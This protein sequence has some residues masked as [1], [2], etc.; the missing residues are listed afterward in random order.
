MLYLVTIG[1][2]HQLD[3]FEECIFICI[4]DPT[5]AQSGRGWLVR[6]GAGCPS[7]V[8]ELQGSNVSETSEQIS[9]CPRRDPSSDAEGRVFGC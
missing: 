9:P 7:L 4:F 3:I 1:D 5:V 2:D 8:Y 6:S